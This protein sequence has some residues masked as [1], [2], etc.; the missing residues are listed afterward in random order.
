MSHRPPCTHDLDDL[1][2][3]LGCE[4]AVLV[5]RLDGHVGHVISTRDR[6][7]RLVAEAAAQAAVEVIGGV[8]AVREPP[9]RE[10]G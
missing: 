5:Y 8:G 3:G 10:E 6:A 4:V 7:D 1:R 2:R 9:L